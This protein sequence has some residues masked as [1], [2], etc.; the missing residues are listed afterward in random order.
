L[1][2]HVLI[3]ELAGLDKERRRTRLEALGDEAGAH[4]RQTLVEAADRFPELLALIGLGPAAAAHADRAQWR[5]GDPRLSAR[6]VGGLALIGSS[7]YGEPVRGRESQCG[8][9]HHAH[10]TSRID[11]GD[12]QAVDIPKS[13]LVLRRAGATLIG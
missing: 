6:G 9:S 10:A 13:A 3:E 4:F 7:S 8:R 1:N 12:P 11:R 5:R 2:D